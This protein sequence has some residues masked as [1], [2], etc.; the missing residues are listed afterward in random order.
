MLL[1]KGASPKA[2]T[3][4][5]AL[6]LACQLFGVNAGEVERATCVWRRLLSCQTPKPNPAHSSKAFSRHAQ[7]N[8]LRGTDA[9]AKIEE[10]ESLL[11][12]LLIRHVNVSVSNDIDMI[13]DGPYTHHGCV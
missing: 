10:W 13:E 2:E 9:P 7:M 6:L 5:Q 1:P 11:P 4:R 3:A 8:C 12:E